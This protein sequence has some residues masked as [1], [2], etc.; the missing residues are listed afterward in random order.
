MN[1]MTSQHTFQPLAQENYECDD[2]IHAV[3]GN[4][5]VKGFFKRMQKNLRQLLCW[6]KN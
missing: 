1:E 2:D 5:K 6:K 3:T 4:K